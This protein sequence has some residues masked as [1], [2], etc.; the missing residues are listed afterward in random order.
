MVSHQAVSFVSEFALSH[1]AKLMIL[2]HVSL[3]S[4]YC[5]K[6]LCI[7]SD[8]HSVRIIVNI[9]PWTTPLAFKMSQDDNAR[10]F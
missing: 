1:M 7:F 4:Y 5:F 3:L 8:V 9:I 10:L 2:S 6:S